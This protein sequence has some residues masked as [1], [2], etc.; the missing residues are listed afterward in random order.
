M[1]RN[2]P[3]TLRSVVCDEDECDDELHRFLLFYRDRAG[4]PAGEEGPSVDRLLVL[5]RLLD[6][7]HVVDVMR[8]TLGVNLRPLDA[9]DV[10]LTIPAGDIPF[11]VIA[12]PAGLARLAW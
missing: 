2:Q 11:D 4:S 10:G 12:A 9:G 5:G 6:K 7:Q 8:D 3:V 1:R